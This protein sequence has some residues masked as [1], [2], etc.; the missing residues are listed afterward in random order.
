MAL[1][2]AASSAPSPARST[3]LLLRPLALLWRL[4]SG[5]VVL[6]LFAFAYIAGSQAI[7]RVQASGGALVLPSSV[8]SSAG[9]AA[10]SVGGGG[11]AANP[12]GGG[13]GV[14]PK[15]YKKEELPEKSLRTFKDV[16]GCDEAKE[17]LREVVEFLKNPTK[18]TRL[19]AKLPKG[20]LLTG[21]PGTGKT[22]LAK[23]VAGEAGV[24]FF[25]RAGSEFEELYVGV[26]SRRMRAL[27]AA[28]KKR[29]PCIVFIDEI[30]AIGGN[31]KHWENHTRK[32]LNQLLVE[33]DG[34]EASEGIIVMAATNLAESLDPAL[35]RPGR[36]DRQVGREDEFSINRQQMLAR[37]RV[38]M[39]GTVAEELV[40]GR[41]RVSSG[42]TDDLRQATSMA[43]HMVAE[44]G[45]SSAIG[46][47]H[48]AGADD[49]HG[50]LG[51]SEATRRAVDA[52]VAAM[53]ADAKREVSEL[54]QER[55]Q[56]LHTL[57]AALLDR[58][59]LS[60][61]DINALLQHQPAAPPPASGGGGGGGG[62]DE[63]DPRGDDDVAPAPAAAQVAS[64]H[65][66]AS[67]SRD[68]AA[69]AQP[70]AAAA[71]PVVMAVASSSGAGGA[72]QAETEAEVEGAGRP[73][74]GQLGY[75][76]RMAHAEPGPGSTSLA[77]AAAGAAAGADIGRQLRSGAGAAGSHGRAA[78]YWGRPAA[79][80]E[81]PDGGDVGLW[82]AEMRTGGGGGSGG[83]GAADARR[84]LPGSLLLEA[85]G[86][87]A[88]EPG[89][90]GGFGA[91]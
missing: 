45:M 48:L 5:A 40:F 4:A 66:G 35:K 31:R 76:E 6:L 87:A 79:Y 58:E 14:E 53:L 10:S 44:C 52:E 23:A 24:P 89:S 60:R 90:D 20:V 30:D 3:P 27:F 86:G 65:A 17:E 37:I 12:G 81:G 84:R 82:A 50:G 46:P 47:V 80:A 91:E 16:K 11:A 13:P 62:G 78:P 75:R 34:F 36:F 63:R 68:A 51:V 26:G 9:P 73:T 32:T 25:Y 41:E 19:G 59:T 72:S 67:T 42:A 70:T 33:M 43:R 74:G 39:G 8:S 61:D 57:A 1:A 29:S 71:V 7:R 28:A 21:P 56:D 64:S 77:A 55:M 83:W 85:R 22:L 18:F 2:P 15:E 54:L 69:A 49:R 88:E 38:C